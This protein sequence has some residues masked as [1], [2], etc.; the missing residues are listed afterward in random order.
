MNCP[1]CEKENALTWR[2]YFKYPLGRYVC[3]QCGTKYKLVRPLW[4]YCWLL[5]AYAAFIFLTVLALKPDKGLLYSCFVLILFLFFFA[6]VDKKIE[7]KYQTR[8]L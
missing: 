2:V 3:F 8:Q 1:S 4:Y 6:V 5:S 7:S